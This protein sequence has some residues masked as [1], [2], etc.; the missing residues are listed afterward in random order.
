MAS[1]VPR[2]IRRKD[3]Y[4]FK[5]EEYVDSG[6]LLILYKGTLRKAKKLA[7]PLFNKRGVRIQ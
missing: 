2:Y 3:R 1:R 7:V 5:I 6:A 4:V